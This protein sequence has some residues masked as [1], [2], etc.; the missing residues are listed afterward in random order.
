MAEQA[1]TPS[2]P[3]AGR[4]SFNSKRGF[5]LA[6][7]GSAVGMGNIWMFPTRVSAYGGG[8]FLVPYLIFVV[9]IASTGVICEMAF[10]RV[11]RKG[12]IGAFSMATE[13][14]FGSKKPGMVMGLL[15]VI[16]S[17]AMAIGYSVVV[18]WIFFYLFTSLAGGVDFSSVD[19]SAAL[20]GGVATQNAFW[21]VIALL[22][23]FSIVIFGIGRGIERAN[24][25]LMP[26]FYVLFV[27]MA[28]YVALLPNSG[29]GYEYLLKFDPA[30]LTDPMIWVFALGQA[31][32]SL[33][34]AGNGTLIYGS[35]LSEKED[36]PNSAKYVAIFDTSAAILA[37]LVIIPAMAN[38]GQVLDTGGPGLMF[39]YLPNL[40]AGMPFGQLVMFVF[41]TA[42]LFGGVT[43]LINLYEAPIA[44][45]Q[46]LT[47]F[48]RKKASVAIGCFGLVVSLLIQQIVS[49]WMD[50]CSI[51]L[52][53]IGAALAAICF[54]WILGKKFAEEQVNLGRTKPL[55]A[56]FYPVAKYVYCGAIIVVLL[57]GAIFGG[58]G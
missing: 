56:W 20:F 44:T 21:Q 3:K 4:D 49:P 32:F 50:V 54:F 22:A 19:A 11:A 26:A 57:A 29:A 16:S 10:G 13:Q 55:G 12:P 30:G 46:E 24:K 6:C 14:R 18:G 53:P 39:I 34:V 37:S 58:I 42:V 40:F 23:T 9:L 17:L 28:V 43:S 35:Y 1:I 27:I 45:L 5:I 31:F 25:I 38:A 33:S 2:E 7:I 41:F 8:T 51:Y 36:I 48:S 52:C 47:G 15:P